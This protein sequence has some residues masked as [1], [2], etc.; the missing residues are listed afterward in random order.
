MPRSHHDSSSSLSR[1][2]FNLRKHHSETFAANDDD[3]QTL[4]LT[5]PTMPASQNNILYHHKH[6]TTA[7]SKLRS[8]LTMFTKPKSSTHLGTK[9]IGTLFGTRRGHVNFAIQ[10]DP[11]SVPAFII[12]LPATTSA[13]VKDLASGAVRVLLECD[14]K[15]VRKS[16]DRKL[17]TEPIWRSYCNGKKCGYAAR[18]DCG[19]E[20]WRVLKAVEMMTAGAG[21]LP[22]GEEG[23]GEVMYMRARFER[24]VG[25]KHSEAFYM[26]SPEGGGG[27]ELSVLLFRV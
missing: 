14:K 27:P 15:R 6:P 18:R 21:V 12:E 2:Y 3:D 23:E 16:G 26:V 17:L 20:E 1:R 22:E 9:V 10:E 5:F 24:V 19:G 4:T 25:S 13:L 11:K 8:A 7:V